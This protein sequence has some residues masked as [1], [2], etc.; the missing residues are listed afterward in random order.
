MRSTVVTMAVSLGLCCSAS[1]EVSAQQA[2]AY[3]PNTIAVSPA[4]QQMLQRQDAGPVTELSGYVGQSLPDSIRLYWDRTLTRYWEVAR[5]D[6]V[7]HIA[8]NNPNDAVKIYVRSSATITFANRVPAEAAAIQR[9]IVDGL[10]S[11]PI[12]GKPLPGVRPRF[13]MCQEHAIYCA[14]GHVYNCYGAVGCALAQQ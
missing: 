3:N 7:Q 8:G 1:L 11:I 5:A 13:G 14:L 9:V 10:G 4:L 2:A 6:I 12:E